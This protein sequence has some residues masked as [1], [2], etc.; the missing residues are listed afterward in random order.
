MA[1]KQRLLEVMGKVNPDFKVLNEEIDPQL[2]KDLEYKDYT[3]GETT[4]GDIILTHNDVSATINPTTGEV[5][6]GGEATADMFPEDFEETV[7]TV[8]K[9]VN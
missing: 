3:V 7:A 4:T 8:L 5:E 1:S 6:F 2:K 9:A